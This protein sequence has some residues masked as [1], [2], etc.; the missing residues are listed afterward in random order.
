MRAKGTRAQVAPIQISVVISAGLALALAAGNSLAQGKGQQ[1]RYRTSA[2]SS[3]SEA[4]PTSILISPDENYRIGPG[5]VVDVQV[6]MAPELSRTF[7]VTAEGTFQMPFVGRVPAKDKTPEELGDYIAERLRGR[8]LKNPIVAVMV[9]QINSH[10]FFVQGAVRRPGVYQIE[11]RPSLLE[12]ITVAGGLAD[13]HGSSALIIRKL[14]GK[15]PEAAEP[16]PQTSRESSSPAPSPQPPAPNSEVEVDAKYE[17][18]TVNINGLLKG[19]FDQNTFVEAGDIINIPP[20]D[21]FFVA[22]EVREPGSFPL[23]E[24]TTLR[25]ALSL[26]QG[27]TFKA[28]TGRG[29][30]FREDPLSG[31][32]QEIKVDIGAVM[33][34]KSEDIAIVANDIVIIPNSRTKSVGGVIL[35]SFGLG[36]SQIPITI[37]R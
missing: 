33:S 36:A 20:T 35:N 23:K 25:Q 5:D 12:L 2:G 29:I 30:I 24:G 28:A 21:I 22:G 32:R 6:E 27:M 37:L 16:A 8:Y 1:D 26:A 11:G 34:G 13:N 17:L 14:K 7:R 19:R 31:K 18:K 15:I 3:S 10:S 4:T 9:K